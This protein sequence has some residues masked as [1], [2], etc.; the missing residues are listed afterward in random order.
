MVRFKEY[1]GWDKFHLSI[2]ENEDT[3]AELGT[4]FIVYPLLPRPNI[5]KLPISLVLT[6]HHR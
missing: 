5:E 6:S 3:K 4:T 1:K 2:I